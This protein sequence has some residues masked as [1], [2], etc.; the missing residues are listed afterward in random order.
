MFRSTVQQ[1]SH[2]GLLVQ[3]PHSSSDP[4]P[5]F[6]TWASPTDQPHVAATPDRVFPKARRALGSFPSQSSNKAV[7]D[8]RR[9]SGY[10]PYKPVGET[11]YVTKG[12]LGTRDGTTMKL[13]Q[14]KR[15]KELVA[16]KFI[17]RVQG[18]GLGR[19]TERE[20]IHHRKLL[21]PNI[22]RFK[23]VYTTEE[24]L[25]IV[26]EYASLGPLEERLATT[27]TLS[28]SVSKKLFRQLV[29]GLLYCHDQ[30]IYH[31]DIRTS[32]LL[33]HGNIYDPTLKVSDFTYA[34]SGVLDSVMRTASA[35][36]PAHSPPELLR[37][38]GRLGEDGYDGA[39]VDVWASGIVLYRMLTGQHPFLD[40]SE[41]DV[42][43]S[44][45]MKRICNCQYRFPSNRIKVTPA[46][47][48]LI[49]KIFQPD[50]KNR[51]KT[52]EMRDHP[53]L[54]GVPL[55]D[56][57]P[58]SSM[59][60]P[61]PQT[62][63]DITE[64][65]E[66]ARKRRDL[67]NAQSAARSTGSN[68]SGPLADRS[69]AMQGKSSGHSIRSGSS[70]SLKGARRSQERKNSPDTIPLEQLKLGRASP[71]NRYGAQGRRRSQ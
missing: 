41:P 38:T 49:S 14:N 32:T 45:V 24:A 39:A 10:S 20:I 56:N 57:E 55:P 60:L 26:M 44:A 5:S 68:N 31:R 54:S 22:I 11:G 34:K 40:P 35:G 53:W 59:L 69:N 37:L 28:E 43:K 8:K 70:N 67:R 65:V 15:T 36:G 48:D 4:D 21:H 71:L 46:C 13:M 6:R 63:D 25:V 30:K 7:D 61:S 33:L 19:G 42:I 18:H 58:P 12:Q 29:D 17:P 23:E 66:R 47:L 3:S 16:A 1:L 62:D 2:F 64:V 50:P 27:G 51:I 9:H 52:E